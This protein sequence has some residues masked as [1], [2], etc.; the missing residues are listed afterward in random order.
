[1]GQ[2]V[3]IQYSIDLEDLPAEM[4]GLIAKAEDRLAHCHRE[5]QTLIQASNRKA[6][7]TTAC[8][9]EISNIR[10][11]LADADFILNDV[12]TIIHSYV[13]YKVTKREK[14]LGP[15]VS[16]PVSEEISDVEYE[17]QLEQQ[18]KSFKDSLT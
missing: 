8:T 17:N 18:V 10:E 16:S 6:I 3:N 5:L 4:E 13:E 12:V 11:G 7:M 15:P 14:V 9:D 2:R 1:M